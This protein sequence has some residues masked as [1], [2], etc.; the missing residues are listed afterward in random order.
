[1]TLYGSGAAK[2][3]SDEE[4]LAIEG[5]GETYAALQ[6]IKERFAEVQPL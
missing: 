5:L 3:I 2:E 4:L 6:A 1:M